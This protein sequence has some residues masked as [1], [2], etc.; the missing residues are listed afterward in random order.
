MATMQH[1]FSRRSQTDPPEEPH[2]L[3]VTGG[4]S[5]IDP[6]R[7]RKVRWFFFKTLFQMVLMEA[8]FGLPLLR[9]VKPPAL[10]R[11][12]KV[13]RRY[14]QMAVEM[15]G[16]TDQARPIHQHARRSAATGST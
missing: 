11:W 8:L 4:K 5:A 16:G 15:G 12:Q 10:P 2:R 14:K 1:P 7:Y 6:R 13:A 3:N 9:W